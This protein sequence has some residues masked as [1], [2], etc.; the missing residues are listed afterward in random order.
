MLLPWGRE[1]FLSQLK[2]QS[3]NNLSRTTKGNV[4]PDWKWIEKGI[5]VKDKEF[6]KPILNTFPTR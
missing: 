1:A 5:I 4:T 2:Y 3:D 6:Y